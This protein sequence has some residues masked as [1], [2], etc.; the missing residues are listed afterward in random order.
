MVVASIVAIQVVPTSAAV[1]V[2]RGT[3]PPKHREYPLS[4]PKTVIAPGSFTLQGRTASVNGIHATGEVVLRGR[5]NAGTY[6][7][8]GRSMTDA[9]GSYRLKVALT[10][11]GRLSLRLATPDGY[12]GI[13]TLSVR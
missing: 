9:R 2:Q 12:V 8:L 10:R 11:R 13:T 5:W 1:G 7:E 3:P 4:G 6:L